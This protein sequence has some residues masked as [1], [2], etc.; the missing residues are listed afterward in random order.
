MKP[1]LLF[2]EDSVTV[3]ETV[4]LYIEHQFK[5]AHARTGAEARKLLDKKY[6]AVLL[7]LNLPDMNGKDLIPEINK[8]DIPV[9]VLT[10]ER[11]IENVVKVINTGVVSDYISKPVDPFRLKKSLEIATGFAF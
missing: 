3:F 1:Q 11:K 7:D 4:C 9:I 5:I 8:Y 6:E 10:G 2:I